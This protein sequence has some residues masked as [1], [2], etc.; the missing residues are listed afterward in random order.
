VYQETLEKAH[1]DNHR[2]VMEAKAGI[3]AQLDN[4]YNILRDMLPS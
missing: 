2:I 3:Q 4:Q 1:A